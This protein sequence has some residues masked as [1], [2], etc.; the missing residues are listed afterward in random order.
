MVSKELRLLAEPNH[1]CL[2]L[3]R[4]R[5]F[6]IFDMQFTRILLLVGHLRQI[7]NCW[8]QAKTTTPHD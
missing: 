4:Y 8:Q 6:S 5:N 2:D 3:V 7:I 1:K